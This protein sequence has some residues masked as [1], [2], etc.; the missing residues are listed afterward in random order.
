MLWWYSNRSSSC[1]MIS[2]V[3]GNRIYMLTQHP[4]G[5]RY[6]LSEVFLGVTEFHVTTR[7]TEVTWTKLKFLTD[8][9]HDVWY[10][11]E[12]MFRSIVGLDVFRS[13]FTFNLW[14]LRE[15]RDSSSV[16]W[17]N[18]QNTPLA[19]RPWIAKLS[20]FISIINFLSRWVFEYDI[21]LLAVIECFCCW[22]AVW[23][24]Y[25]DSSWNDGC[26]HCLHM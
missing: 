26:Y 11:Y 17:W 15:M 21:R 5:Y 4:L 2:S 25:L 8:F 14:F 23:V 9:L 12:K 18:T 16:V 7:G 24:L 6:W 1:S 22:I 3:T 19:I 10:V 20:L 13:Q